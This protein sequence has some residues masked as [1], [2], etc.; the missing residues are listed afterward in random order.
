MHAIVPVRLKEI[1]VRVR[2][3]PTVMASYR[4]TT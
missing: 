4:T 3:D 1:L 2:G